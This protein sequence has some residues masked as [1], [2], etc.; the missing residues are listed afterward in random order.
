MYLKHLSSLKN[1]L[2][3]FAI[4]SQYLSLKGV[5]NYEIIITQEG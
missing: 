3:L 4:L 2:F 5:N 1:F